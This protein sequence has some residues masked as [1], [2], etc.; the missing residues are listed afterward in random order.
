MDAPVLICESDS[1][2]IQ[3]LQTSLGDKVKWDFAN[4]GKEAQVKIYRQKYSLIFLDLDLQNHSAVE[5]FRYIKT[6]HPGLRV[7]LIGRSHEQLDEFG[8]TKKEMQKLGV[9]KTMLKPFATKQVSALV[10]E[11]Q[12][13]SSWR[14]VSEISATNEV[15]EM[16]MADNKFTRIKITD[17]LNGET[18]VFDIYLRINAN[19]YLKIFCRGELYDMNRIKT[20]QEKGQADFLYFLTSERAAFLNYLNEFATNALKSQ[21]LSMD[22]KVEMVQSISDQYVQEVFTKG[23]RTEIFEE[24]K[25]LCDNVHTLIKSKEGVDIILAQLER[26][27]S[28]SFS[29]SFLTAFF[30][31][32]IT[33]QLPWGTKGTIEKVVQGALLIDIGKLKLPPHLRDKPVDTMTATELAQYQQHPKI[34]V[35]MLDSSTQLPE[36]IKQIVYHHHELVNGTGYPNGLTGLKIFPPAKIVSFANDFVD[37][38]K[39]LGIGPLDGVKQFLRVPGVLEKYD[40]T[41][42]KAF[43]SCFISPEKLKKE[44]N[45]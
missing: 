8:F 37:F 36:A 11:L 16:Q 29:D 31:S 25:K 22:K 30:A 15:I 34:G 45:K 2:T 1:L 33:A 40:P 27:D 41:I 14:N 7:V 3:R 32:M 17:F 6:T 39:P 26:M 13:Q 44:K 12:Q 19:K 20:Y 43:L 18:S 10:E 28:K 4:T 9:I 35:D 38:L 23:I 42:I 24:G 5:V 21:N